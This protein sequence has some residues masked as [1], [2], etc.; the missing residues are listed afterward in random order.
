MFPG[1]V[2]VS[3]TIP[4]IARLGWSDPILEGWSI[5]VSP[6]AF[7]GEA[8]A[9]YKPRMAGLSEISW[10]STILPPSIAI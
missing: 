1:A 7:A 10:G 9:S 4:V 2:K 5:M 3:M 8:L 6:P